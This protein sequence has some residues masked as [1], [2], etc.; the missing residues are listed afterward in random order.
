MLCPQLK[1]LNEQL[2]EEEAQA[3]RD[4]FQ[5]SRENQGFLLSQMSHK[6]EKV[7]EEKQEEMVQAEMSKQWMGARPPIG[8]ASR[9]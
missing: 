3:I 2:R 1:K 5:R 4:K 7:Y 8:G 9:L 6:R